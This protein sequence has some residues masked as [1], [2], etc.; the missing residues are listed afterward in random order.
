MRILFFAFFTMIIFLVD[1]ALAQQS[2][3]TPDKE[4]Y[5]P[6]SDYEQLKKEFDSLKKTVEQMQQ[7]KVVTT[8]I[9]QVPQTETKPVEQENKKIVINPGSKLEPGWERVRNPNWM[10][11]GK[12]GSRNARIAKFGDM[13]FYM[14][15]DTV[16]RVQALRESHVADTVGAS[17]VISN[18]HLSSGFQTAFGNLSFLADSPDMELY[19]SIF[20]ASRP[21]PDMMQGDEGYVIFHNLPDLLGGSK[22]AHDLFDNVNIKAGQFE[23]DY[24]DAH[25]LRSDN[26]RVQQ[27]PL[28]GNFVVDPRSSEVGM[29]AYSSDKDG[30]PIGWLAGFGS[31][32]EEEDFSKD[33]GM[34]LHAKV[35]DKQIEGLRPSASV[36]WVDQSNGSP[37]TTRT[38]MFRSDRS[39]G[40]YG[41]VLDDGSAPG[42][43]FVG[44]GQRVLA[45][46]FDL[47]WTKG[48]NELYGNFGYVQ[49]TDTNGNGFGT[50]SDK[51]LYYA[52]EAKHNLTPRLYLAT[53]F[54]GATAMELT[55][56][57]DL[58]SD[59]RSHGMVDRIQIGGGY[60]LNKMTLLKVEYVYQCYHD[61]K[62]NAEQ[63]SGV[64]AWDD[65][66]FYGLLTEVSIAF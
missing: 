33:H 10:D 48:K 53:R 57:S 25:Y 50:P 11:P 24:G 23:V 41:G 46:Q 65:P 29:E 5:V 6:R 20:I 47:T 12:V 2:T 8:T 9:I 44:N 22:L 62:N 36:Y 52:A 40:P 30:S 21:H 49:D 1:P 14:G 42:Q 3:S 18:G 34:S 4:Q 27:N 13:D 38:N 32:G 16:G 37:S 39:G 51:W 7:Q 54:S 55:S 56:L 60:W 61:F 35:W 59:V 28:I 19:F 64:D 15:V 31:G 66:S 43:V 17:S 63:V 45:S 58:S 26:A